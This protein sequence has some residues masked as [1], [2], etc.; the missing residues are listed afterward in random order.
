MKTQQLFYMMD[1]YALVDWVDRAKI[2][3]SELRKPPTIDNSHWRLAR[4]MIQE[5]EE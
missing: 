1:L 3:L 2:L 4:D 5:I